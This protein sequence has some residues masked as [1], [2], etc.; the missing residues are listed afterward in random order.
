MVRTTALLP[1][2]LL[3]L[4]PLASAGTPE[5]PELTDPAG[6][7][8]FAPGNEYADVTAAWISDE[9]PTDFTVNLALAKFTD[10]AAQATGYTIQFEH[11]GVGFGVV[12]FY[13]QNEWF[14][15]TGR[16][17]ADTG[18]VNE[19]NDTEGSF[20]AGTPA[21]LAIKF[22]KN[23][24]PH[25]DPNDKALRRFTGGSADF[26]G[27]APFFFDVPRPEQ[28][29]PLHQICDLAEGQLTYVFTSGEHAG[30]GGASVV[31]EQFG[32]NVTQ[33]TG[34]NPGNITGESPGPEENSVPAP[35]AV[36]AVLAGA[37]LWRRRAA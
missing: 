26:K 31:E 2:L 20:T 25:T 23:L 4:A 37:Y 18:D 7:C 27:E 6:D 34:G 29:P 32:G 19:Y 30:H 10:A 28:A 5:A 21:V 35:A 3:A 33:E 36:F 8:S 12:A 14:F 24:F 16:V 13:F 9:T 11:Q 15:G 22:P 1:L 17:N